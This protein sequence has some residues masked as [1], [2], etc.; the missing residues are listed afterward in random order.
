MSVG[1]LTLQQLSP[2]SSKHARGC[3]WDDVQLEGT[4]A[5]D[6][7]KWRVAEEWS[8]NYQIGPIEYGSHKPRNERRGFLPLAHRLV[9]LNPRSRENIMRVALEALTGKSFIKIRPPWLRNPLGGRNLEIDAW[10]DELKLACEFQGYQ[11][12]LSKLLSQIVR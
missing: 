5:A 3:Q 1:K 6:E 10:N 7:R 8:T 9:T 4:H 2:W 12:S 11:H